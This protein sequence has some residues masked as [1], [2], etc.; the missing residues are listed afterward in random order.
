M[1]LDLNFS[2]GI[3]V[4]LG[5]TFVFLS[6]LIPYLGLGGARFRFRG[7]ARGLF[8]RQLRAQRLLARLGGGGFRR[9][10]EAAFFGL[11]WADY[12]AYLCRS[13]TE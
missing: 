3:G 7:D 6:R 12:W 4:E 11:Q 1:N 13:L 10:R 2:L 8:E 9:E 5:G